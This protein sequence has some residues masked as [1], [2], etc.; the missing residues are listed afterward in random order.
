MI[1]QD[2]MTSLNPYLTIGR[3][4]GLVL[5]EH[6]GLSRAAARQECIAMLDA[7]G[8]PEAAQR[9]EQY[10]HE[11][12][13]GM[14]QRVMIAAALLCRPAL[15][16]ADEPTTALDVTVQAQILALMKDLRARFGT[17]IIMITHDLSVVAGL[18]DRI[19]VMQKGECREDGHGREYLSTSPLILIPARCSRQ[20][21]GWTARCRRCLC[22][23]SARGRRPCWRSASCVSSSRW[24]RAA[25]WPANAPVAGR[26]RRELSSWCPAKCWAWWANPAAAS[27]PWAER[28]CNWC[29]WPPGR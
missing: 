19:L 27:P 2:P 25:C 3:Q 21:P 6:R 14:R 11:L 12:S 29:R 8:I 23:V 22:P 16:I 13:G 18:A 26:G 28:C 10:P 7:V 20:C 17:A 15:L 9:L 5:R 24:Q 4:M 1:F